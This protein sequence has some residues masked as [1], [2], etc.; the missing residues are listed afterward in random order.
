MHIILKRRHVILL[1]LEAFLTGFNKT[2]NHLHSN[3]CEHEQKYCPRCQA[4][5]ECKVGSILL[6]QCSA[7]PL[8][9][10]ERDYMSGQYNDCLCANCMKDL[11]AEYHDNLFKGKL[12]NMFGMN[13]T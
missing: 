2:I 7:V 6:C 12:K 5:F 11:K 9:Q 4:R 8:N 10:D 13:H 1:H 3:M